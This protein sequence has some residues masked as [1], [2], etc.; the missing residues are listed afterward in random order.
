MSASRRSIEGPLFH[1]YLLAGPGGDLDSFPGSRE[2]K[3]GSKFIQVTVGITAEVSLRHVI[4][5]KRPKVSLTIRL[6]ACTAKTVIEGV[7]H[8]CQWNEMSGRASLH[9]VRTS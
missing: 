6:Y 4:F 2:S 5:D 3:S 9:P 1:A 7:K 8:R